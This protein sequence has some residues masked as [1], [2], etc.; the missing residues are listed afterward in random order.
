MPYGLQP[1]D[2][3][4]CAMRETA[5]KLSALGHHVDEVDMPLPLDQLCTDLTSLVFVNAAHVVDQVKTRSGCGDDGF[6]P[7][8]LIMAAFGRAMRADEYVDAL[9]RWHDYVRIAATFFTRFDVFLTPT[10]ARADLRIGELALSAIE[11]R[12]MRLA[13]RGGLSRWMRASHAFMQR[14][15]QAFSYTPYAGLAN[16]TGMPAMS[17]PLYW[18]GQ[19]LPLGVQFM[20]PVGGEARLFRLAAQLEAAHPWFSRVPM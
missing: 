5:H 8:T 15:R 10:L 6:E 17:L 3:A 2:D 13:Q 14:Q 19:G 1:S 20:G 7:D 11:Q 16:L 18:T 4:R 12:L 9:G